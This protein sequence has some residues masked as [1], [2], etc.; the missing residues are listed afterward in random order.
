LTWRTVWERMSSATTLMPTS[1]DGD[2]VW[3][4]DARKL[5]GSP[6]C[7]GGRNTTWSTDNV[8]T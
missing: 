3:F 1:I 7:T 4:T 6:T 5:T 8:T 2:L